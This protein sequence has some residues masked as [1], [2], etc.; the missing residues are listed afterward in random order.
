MIWHLYDYYLNPGG[1]Y[2][3]TKK[4]CEDLHIQYPLCYVDVNDVLTFIMYSYNDQSIWIVNS[5]YVP[6]YN[7]EAVIEVLH[8][9]STSLFSKSIQVSSITP[10]SALQI[11]VLPELTGLS[12]TY[13]VHLL[14]LRYL[15]S[16]LT[17]V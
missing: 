2:F 3:G 13:F 9:N 16:L 4:A 15:L 14:L 7:V 17:L 8:F 12:A 6:F 10:D 1:S 11:Y 5:L